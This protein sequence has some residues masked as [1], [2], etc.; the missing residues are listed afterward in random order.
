MVSRGPQINW[1][2]HQPTPPA[3]TSQRRIRL[4]SSIFQ[5]K[6]KAHN[7]SPHKHYNEKNDPDPTSAGAL[8][9]RQTRMP[10]FGLT[11]PWQNG[12]RPVTASKDIAVV[13]GY[14]PHPTD[15]PR[16]EADVGF[17]PASGHLRRRK[18]CPRVPLDHRL[19]GNR[20]RESLTGQCTLV[21]PV[22]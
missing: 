10:Q 3:Y 16:W 9:G 18:H 8:V 7:R 1:D 14:P 17:P 13:D 12:F 20:A 2:N 19:R 21:R 5:R 4:R 6:H 22:K 11:R 15:R